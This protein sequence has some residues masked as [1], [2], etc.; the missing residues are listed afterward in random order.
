MGYLLYNLLMFYFPSNPCLSFLYLAPNLESVLYFSDISSMFDLIG[1]LL[2][3]HI[4]AEV[5]QNCNALSTNAIFS[6]HPSL[7]VLHIQKKSK[8]LALGL[9]FLFLA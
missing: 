9:L 8:T 1:F 6:L 2:F 3:G 5:L 7:Y 4:Q